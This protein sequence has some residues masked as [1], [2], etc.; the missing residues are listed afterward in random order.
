MILIHYYNITQILNMAKEELS[1]DYLIFYD[2]PQDFESLEIRYNSDIFTSIEK[3]HDDDA[4]DLSQLISFENLTMSSHGRI[5]I[6]IDHFF[7]NVRCRNDTMRLK[8]KTD[9]G[10]L[11]YSVNGEYYL[12]PMFKNGEP[13][14]PIICFVKD[15]KIQVEYRISRFTYSLPTLI[16]RCTA[17]AIMCDYHTNNS[18]TAKKVQL[19]ANIV[20]D[21]TITMFIA[22]YIIMC[23]YKHYFS[24]IGMLVHLVYKDMT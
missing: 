4:V 16:K 22:K 19:L 11:I 20:L 23:S 3:N 14:F 5:L 13:N 17:K 1:K 15:E 9:V 8:K 6:A 21:G 12:I 18:C 24:I 7:N 2:N 10:E